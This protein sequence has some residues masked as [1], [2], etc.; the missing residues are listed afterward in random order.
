M[1]LLDAIRALERPANAPRSARAQR[2]AAAG[3]GDAL[4]ALL[5]PPDGPETLPDDPE[6]DEGPP[7]LSFTPSAQARMERRGDAVD[8]R[9]TARLEQAMEALDRQGARR[10]LVLDGDRAWVADV[11]HR[12]ID[13]AMS[14]SEALDQVFVDLDST[15]VIPDR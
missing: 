13:R 14:R 10:A 2:P 4:G 5:L 1:N 8:P 3:F 7:A 12:V 15:F 9:A 6:G 11:P